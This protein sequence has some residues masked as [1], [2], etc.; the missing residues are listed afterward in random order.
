MQREILEERGREKEKERWNSGKKRP[1]QRNNQKERCCTK[2]Y[3]GLNM[4]LRCG[5]LR[6]ATRKLK[7]RT[8]RE[9]GGKEKKER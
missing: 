6:D 5:T 2:M 3:I 1:L 9:K 7:E 8:E 4:E